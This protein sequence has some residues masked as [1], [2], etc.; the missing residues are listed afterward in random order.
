MAAWLHHQLGVPVERVV[1][2]EALTITD[3]TFFF[4]DDTYRVS[5][6]VAPP[7]RSPACRAPGLED[8]SVNL[9]RRSVQDSL[10]E[11]LRRMDPDVYYGELLTKELPRLAA[12]SE[13][14]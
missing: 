4:D 12:C 14:E 8:R 6:R 9:A 5:C 13:G 3:I 11:D 2:P 1:D 10:M 7:R